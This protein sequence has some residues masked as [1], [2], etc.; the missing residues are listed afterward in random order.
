LFC[1]YSFSLFS[2]LFVSLLPLPFF[3]YLLSL[4]DSFLT[5]L[6]ISLPLSIVPSCF[7]HATILF[8]HDTCLIII[9]FTWPRCLRRRP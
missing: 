6:V 5:F 1:W 2:L 4:L 7:H 8:N 3:F 9:I